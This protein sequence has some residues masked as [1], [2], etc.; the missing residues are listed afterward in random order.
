MKTYLFAYSKRGI[1]TAES[2]AAALDGEKLCY[3]APSH[4][5]G[6]FCPSKNPRQICMAALFPRLMR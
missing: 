1:E 6:G 3:A 2:I 4:A 5:K